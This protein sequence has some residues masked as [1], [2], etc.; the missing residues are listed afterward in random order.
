MCRWRL[1]CI[2]IIVE[3]YE[4]KKGAALEGQKELEK[5]EAV[6]HRVLYNKQTR[7]W[8]QMMPCY[9]FSYGPSVQMSV[10][11]SFGLF[12]QLRL[13]RGDKNDLPTCTFGQDQEPEE[14]KLHLEL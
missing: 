1:N 9:I 3:G 2:I 11:L 12:V 8:Q 7:A 14:L 13:L 4:E 5:A 6:Q 10:R